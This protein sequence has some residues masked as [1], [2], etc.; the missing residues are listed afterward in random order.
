VGQGARIRATIPSSL[1][2]RDLA[3][4]LVASACKLVPRSRARFRNEVMSAFSEALNNVV[5]HGRPSDPA[6]IRIEIDPAPD[7]LT[8][9]LVDHGRSFDP[10]T[11]PDPDLASLPESGLGIFIMR[12]FMDHLTY[13][14]GPP[15]VLT[16]TKYLQR[17]DLA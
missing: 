1:E 11:A 5:L 10:R 14:S 15:N 17:E 16:M 2:Y 12:S 7:R 8:I 4:R 6:E 9:R 3:I 13:A